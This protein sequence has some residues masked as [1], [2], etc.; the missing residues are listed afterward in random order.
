MKRSVRWLV[1]LALA[2][3]LAGSPV[4]ASLLVFTADLTATQVFKGTGPDGT[5]YPGS[6][7]TG[8]GHATVWIDTDAFTITTDES[9]TGLSGPVD[10]SHMHSALPGQPTDDLFFHEVLDPD[11][12]DSPYRTILCPWDDGT[13][14]YCAPG[15]FGYL[16]DVLDAADGH[17]YPGG[18][19]TLLDT[20]MAGGIYI[21]LHTQALPKGEIRGQLEPVPAPVAEPASLGLLAVGLAGLRASRS[22]RR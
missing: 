1:G 14:T 10:R 4:H 19:E 16:Y 18:F 6:D 5:V 20:F 3:L 12:P 8:T 22:R 17:G 7:S 9:W 21:D 2:F 11:T 15:D 13:F